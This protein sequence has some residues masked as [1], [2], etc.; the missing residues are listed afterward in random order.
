MKPGCYPVEK[1]VFRQ[2]EALYRGIQGLF[3]SFSG[4]KSGKHIGK[5]LFLLYNGCNAFFAKIF[6]P[7]V[8]PVRWAAGPGAAAGPPET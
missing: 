6:P 8:R 3:I 4:I 2:A 5:R 7:V 1:R